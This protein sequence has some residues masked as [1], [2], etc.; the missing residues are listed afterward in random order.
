MRFAKVFDFS[1]KQYDIEHA[2]MLHADSFVVMPAAAIYE[3]ERLEEFEEVSKKC[4][5]YLIGLTPRVF[6]EEVEQA[7]QMALIKFKVGDNPVVVK[8]RL[9]EGSTLVKEDQLFRVLGKDGEEHGIDDVDMAQAIKQV[10]PVHFDVLYIGQAYG[11]AGERAALDRLEKHETL[12]KISLQIGAPPGKQLTVLLLEVISANRMLTMFNPFAKD[13]SSGTE[14]IR[15]G[16]DKLYGTTE[17]ERVALYEA[18]LIRYFQ[19]RYNKDFKDSFPSTDMK[20]LK[21]CYDKDF[22]SIIAEI[23]FD[24]LPWDLKSE[25]VPAAQSHIAKHSLHTAEERSMFFS[26]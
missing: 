12:Q 4:H 8:S 18:S 1:K 16:I 9:P 19:P 2:L 7:G 25:Q 3:K 14:R 11:K 15:A 6:L 10:H 22:S 21:D 26:S 23:N 24:D 20:V 5:I 13:L 17:K